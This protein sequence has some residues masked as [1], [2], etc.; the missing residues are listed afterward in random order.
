MYLSISGT[1]SES[2]HPPGI[3]SWLTFKVNEA[4]TI[5]KT[6]MILNMYIL[7]K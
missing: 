2:D 1:A 5:P 3:P 7:L 6:N 4:H